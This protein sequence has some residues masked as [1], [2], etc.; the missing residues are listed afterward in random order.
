M[1]VTAEKPM[2]KTPPVPDDRSYH[3]AEWRKSS[4]N[5][6]L[7]RLLEPLDVKPGAVVLDVGCGSGYVSAYFSRD[8][9]V[10]RNLAVDL[11]P[12]SEEHTSELQSH[13]DLVCRLLLEKKKKL[14]NLALKC[15]TP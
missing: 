15:H 9:T 3:L 4:N 5:A 1:F 13:S 14:K 10:R 8:K 2:S 6:Y 7:T 11:V 12:R